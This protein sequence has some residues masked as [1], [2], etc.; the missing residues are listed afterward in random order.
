MNVLILL[1]LYF[2]FKVGINHYNFH[3]GNDS[4]VRLQENVDVDKNSI[5]KKIFIY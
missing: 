2:N 4:R 1:V 3:L 5:F